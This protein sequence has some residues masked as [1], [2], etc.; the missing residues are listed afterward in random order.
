MPV[1]RTQNRLRPVPPRTAQMTAGVPA[2]AETLNAATADAL[3][4]VVRGQGGKVLDS[5]SARILGQRGGKKKAER[6][7]LLRSVPTLLR[8][9]GMR[10]A[11]VAGFAD[12]IA[13]ALE[14]AAAEAVRLEREIGGGVLG[15]GP[16]SFVDS[17]ALQLAASRWKFATGEVLEA[18]RLADASRA[19]LMSAEDQA[20]RE[21]QIRRQ[22]ET[23]RNGGRPPIPSRFLVRGGKP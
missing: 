19:N 14:F 20:A 4:R 5:E 23:T 8:G 1:E 17:A 10:G 13:D 15:E 22:N 2:P 16:R 12:Y 21:A 7:R 9:F 11:I 3:A 18:S 6:D